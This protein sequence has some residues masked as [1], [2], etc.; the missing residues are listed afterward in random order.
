MQD[1]IFVLITLFA[2]GLLAALIKGS[3]SLRQ[4]AGDE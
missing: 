3:E 4:G 2:F 1:I